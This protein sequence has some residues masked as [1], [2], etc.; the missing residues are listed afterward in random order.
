MKRLWARW[1]EY[2][3]KRAQKQKDYDLL[4]YGTGF[5]IRQWWGW[6]S[7]SPVGVITYRANV[8]EEMYK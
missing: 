4:L 3:R 8:E 6:K 7:L 5:M 2:T 1:I